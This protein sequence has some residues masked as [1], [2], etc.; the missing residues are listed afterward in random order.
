[1]PDLSL[2]LKT[3][4]SLVPDG[5]RVCD[6]GTDHGYLAIEL[7]KSDKVSSIIA[8]DINSQPLKNAEYNI[9]KSGVRGIELRLCDGLSGIKVNEVDTIIIAGMGGEVI[10]GI[11]ERGLEIAKSV[12]TIIL[13]PT[14]SP[15]FLRKFLYD[16]GF[17]I[18]SEVPVS[19]NGKLYSV[20]VVSPT[21]QTSIKDDY[22]YYI[23]KVS[24]RD[25]SGLLYIQKQLNRCSKCAESLKNIPHKQR[26]YIY[27]K[28]IVEDIENHLKNYTSENN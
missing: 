19:E 11:L 22:F 4:A 6:I 15:E 14:T 21:N 2:R 3:I 20:I 1:M 16:N 7:K 23:G 26:E 17:E 10:S 5:A 18:E 25:K 12:K 8:A 28:N 27:Y 24:P 9:K 13:Q